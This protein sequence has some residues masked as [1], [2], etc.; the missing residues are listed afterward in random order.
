MTNRVDLVADDG[1][2]ARAS[3]ALRR[4]RFSWTMRLQIVDVVEEHLIEIADRR[5]DVA[6][7]GDVDDEQRP[8]A[9][10]PHDLF[11][12]RARQHR[13]GRAGGGDDDVG[14]R[15]RRVERRPTGLRAPPSAVGQRLRRGCSVR[16]AIVICL[17]CCACRCTP[18]SFAISPAPRIS[19]LEPCRGCRRSSCAS[20]IAA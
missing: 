19:T 7:H 13:L 17:T 15:Q 20:A 8:V 16:L 5:L 2:G 18:V 3:S 9:P 4:A 10:R 14:G 6:R 1:L 11:D 12:A